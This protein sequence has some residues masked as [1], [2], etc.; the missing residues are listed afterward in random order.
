M[1]DGYGTPA[2]ELQSTPT[3]PAQEM[4]ML[5]DPDAQSEEWSDEVWARDQ[6]EADRKC[7]WMA[8]NATQK[9]GKVVVIQGKAQMV[10]KPKP[11]T[12]G[13]PAV[14]GLFVCQFRSEV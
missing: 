6:E 14:D 5:Q 13:K 1:I 9:G 2:P 3:P 7:Q 4:P 10:T 11:A 12:K 8:D